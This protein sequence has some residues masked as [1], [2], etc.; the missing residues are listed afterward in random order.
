MDFMMK[1]DR[2]NY[3][4]S[5]HK[6]LRRLLFLF[7]IELGA[8]DMTCDEHVKSLVQH[9]QRVKDYLEDHAMHEESYFH[10]F[11]QKHIPK[12]CEDLE[13]EHQ[14]Q[15]LVLQRISTLFDEVLKEKSSLQ[16]QN[17]GWSLYLMVNQF[18]AGYLQ[19]LEQ[20]EA[21]IMPAL[22]QK[23]DDKTL[24]EPMQAFI[25]SMTKEDFHS[26]KN[27]FLPAI[28]PQEK[29]LIFGSL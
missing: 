1:C 2:V 15:D 17:C 22:W 20:E 27:D 3:Y 14:A 18:I 16:R 9:Y 12:E 5:I 8:A 26:S 6:T 10:P 7:S 13:R 23:C 21:H 29:V 11:I 4:Q 28:S 25:Q 19:H 24:L